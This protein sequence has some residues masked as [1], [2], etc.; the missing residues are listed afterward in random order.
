MTVAIFGYAVSFDRFKNKY[1]GLRSVSVFMVPD[2]NHVHS[3]LRELENGRLS[4]CIVSQPIL[5]V[6]C[7]I[8]LA[9]VVSGNPILHVSLQVWQL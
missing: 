6:S 7:Q 2:V 5:G 4:D 3:K 8:V 9:S 1:R